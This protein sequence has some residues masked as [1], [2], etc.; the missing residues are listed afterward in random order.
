MAKQ[1]VQLSDIAKDLS[2][3]IVRDK[4]FSLIGPLGTV[5]TNTLSTLY[6]ANYLE[7]ASTNI[8]L[9]CVITTKELAAALPDRLG[10]IISEAPQQTFHKIDQWLGDNEHYWKSFKTEIGSGCDIHETVVIP[11]HNVRIGNNVQI[12]PNVVIHERTIIGDNTIVGVG[13]VIG[14]AGFEKR[15]SREQALAPHTGGVSIGSHVEIQAQC[16]VDRGVFGVQTELKDYSRLGSQSYIAH[17][18]SV[19]KGTQIA[20]SVTVCGSVI[21]GEDI[22]IAPSAIISNGLSIGDEAF[23]TLGETLTRDLEA[24]HVSLGGRKLSK[25]RYEKLIGA[26]KR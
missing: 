14:A 20:P 6:D 7:Q 8:N 18:V 12:A 9:S 25:E 10:I 23:I 17:N 5:E 21:M 13:T 3:T 2:L 1:L 16:C 11:S 26:L 24:G 15:H 22:W 4:S 19:G